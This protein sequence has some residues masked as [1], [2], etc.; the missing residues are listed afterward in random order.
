M[1]SADK[2]LTIV[3][4]MFVAVLNAR[5]VV[6]ADSVGLCYVLLVKNQLNKG[7]VCVAA[8]NE[9]H[10]TQLS[11]GV[12][13]VSAKRIKLKDMGDDKLEEY[14]LKEKHQIPIVVGPGGVLYMTDH[15]HLM[16]AIWKENLRATRG[17][18]AVVKE[19]VAAV[20]EDEF[21]K[22]MKENHWMYLVDSKGKDREARELPATLGGLDDD[23]YR[24][25]AYAVRE[26]GGFCKAGEFAEFAW[27]EF[28]RS[29]GVKSGDVCAAKAMACSESAKKIPGYKPDCSIKCPDS[30]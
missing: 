25:L 24:S 1:R 15:H 6:A 12:D 11:I 17:V 29:N 8:L 9:L 10:P 16:S 22:K 5:H 28:F 3:V 4:S 13:E 14:L 7:T 21:W 23:P 2:T 27:G 30:D 26:Q 19:N 20:G 18:Y